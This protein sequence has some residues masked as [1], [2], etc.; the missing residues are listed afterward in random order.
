MD[1]A[2]HSYETQAKESESLRVRGMRRD[3]RRN[4]VKKYYQFLMQE[5]E[6]VAG[7]EGSND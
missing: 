4:F 5:I 1:W 6:P 3:H 2:G 7:K